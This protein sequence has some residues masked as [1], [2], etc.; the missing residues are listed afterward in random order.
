VKYRLNVDGIDEIMMMVGE[1]ISKLIEAKDAKMDSTPLEASRYD[2]FS[3]FHPHYKCKMDKAHI[4][5]IGTFPIFMNYTDGLVGDSPQ[6]PIHIAALLKMNVENLVKNGMPSLLE[7]IF[8]RISAI[9]LRRLL[10]S[11]FRQ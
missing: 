11:V 8:G 5:M 1:K 6:V 2:F 4:T 10:C 7:Y 3:D 9:P